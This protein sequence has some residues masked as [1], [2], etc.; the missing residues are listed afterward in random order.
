MGGTVYFHQKVCI[1]WRFSLACWLAVMSR[2]I[3]LLGVTNGTTQLL[4]HLLHRKYLYKET[5]LVNCLVTLH[6]GSF[7]EG[8]INAGCLSFPSF[9]IMYWFPINLWIKSDLFPSLPF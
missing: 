1:F 5:S 2:S 9:K 3:N 4:L 8:R 7:R 6:Y